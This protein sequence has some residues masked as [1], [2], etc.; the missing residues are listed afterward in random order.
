MKRLNLSLV[1]VIFLAWPG[2]SSA[3]NWPGFRGPTGQGVSPETKLPTKWSATENIAWRAE[4]PGQG[5]SSPIVWGDRV[6]VTTATEE[7]E[8]CHVLGLDRKNG[9]ILW[10]VEALRQKRAHK[11]RKNSY[12]TPTPVTDGEYIYAVFNDGG[13]AA[14]TVD[15]QPAWTNHDISYYSQ[16]G[17][18]GSPIL[19]KDTLIMSFDGSS[20]GPDKKLGWQIPWQQSF[21]LALDKKTGRERWRASRGPSRIAHTTPLIVHQ[22][23]YDILV[24]NVGDVI[25]GFEPNGGHRLWTVKAEGEGVVPSPVFGDGLVFAASGFGNPRLRAIKL[26]EEGDALT[27]SIAWEI[28]RN[29]PMIPSGVYVKPHLFIC[30]EKGIATCLDAPSGKVIWQE[31]LGSAF[32]A[33]PVFADGHIYFLSESGQTTVINAGPQFTVIKRNNVDEHCQASIAV[34]QGQ[35]FLRTQ[36]HLYCIGAKK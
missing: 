11:E 31:R 28:K 9:K 35:L 36:S 3:Q 25:Q 19:Y 12:A 20:S 5:W 16:H 1:V 29:V 30:S 10:D 14:L 4:I 21:L 7:G 18:G 33:S 26:K 6:F 22:D 27:R 15:G 2:L 32:S 17:L 24:S 13:I 8:S 34:S 23:G